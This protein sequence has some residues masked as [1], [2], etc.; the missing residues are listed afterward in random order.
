MKVQTLHNGDQFNINK[1]LVMPGWL[2]ESYTLPHHY[3][4]PSFSQF[5][6]V[7]VKKL[8][9]RFNVN[10][11]LR[12]DNSNLMRV[13]EERIGEEGEPHAI[14]TP[15]GWVASGGK[16]SEDPV[17]YWSRRI[18]VQ[19]GETNKDQKIL[20]L[21][22]TVRN[23]SLLNKKTQPS[24]ND[25]KAEE[26]VNDSIKVVDGHYE[27]PVPLKSNVDKLP[28][29]FDQANASKTVAVRQIH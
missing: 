3:N 20:E 21:Q 5:D 2:D 13:L 17:S 25:K 7:E 18:A 14:K 26:I 19:R 15:I 23:L 1:T 6:N 8:P 10:I 11:L 24:I 29:N 9:H 22:Q 27:I 28:S 4:L 12:L 16:F